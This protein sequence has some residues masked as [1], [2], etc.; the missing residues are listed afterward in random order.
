MMCLNKCDGEAST[1]GDLGP[2]EAVRPWKKLT[3]PSFGM[4]LQDLGQDILEKI[5]KSLKNYTFIIGVQCISYEHVFH[6]FSTPSDGRSK[7]SSKMVPPHSA[8]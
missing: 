1:M 7:A 3:G 8:I 6:S 2:L 5:R 4:W